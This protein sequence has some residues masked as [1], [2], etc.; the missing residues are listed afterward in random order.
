MANT[1]SIGTGGANFSG[2]VGTMGPSFTSGPGLPDGF[3]AA[4][5]AERQ[6]VIDNQTQVNIQSE[7]D[8]RAREIA[9]QII[10]DLARQNQAAANGRVFTR[11]DLVSDIIE[12]QKTEVT[13]G[14]FS[15]NAGTLNAVYTSSAQ[16]VSSK[17]YFY[18]IF[19][20][21]A[22][23]SESQFAV[24][25][26]HRLGSGSSALGTLNDSPTRAIYSQYRLLLLQ[27]TDT[28]FTFANSTDS[29]S[30]YFVNYTRARIKEKLDAGAWQLTLGQLSGSAVPNNVHTGSNV[31]LATN[32][33]FITLIDDSSNTTVTNV[34]NGARL[35]NIVSGSLT[36]GVY[37]SSS[38]VFYGLAYPDLGI[39]A[40]N[41]DILDV[42]ASF[43]TVTGSNIA[44]DNAFKLFTAISGAMATST[45]FAAQGR[46]AETVSST[47]YFV[48]VKNAEYNFSNNPTFVTGSVGE[49][50]QPT[51]IGDPKVYITTIGMYNNRQELLAVGKLSQPIKKTFSNEVLIKVKLDF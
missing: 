28:T 4:I 40:L 21:T 17:N 50:A 3:G 25:Y 39:L 5:E 30:V 18:D 42:S 43:N 46:S 8:R 51:F 38:P 33:S 47:H 35:F 49:I 2:A 10:A 16:S 44:G 6:R 22:S 26:G 15:G 19:N 29:N 27:P 48:R 32:P 45:T 12:N 7:I 36:D 31:R 34:V 1:V 13:T 11:F 41:A 37:S 9:D 14:V 24:A 23:T 20:G